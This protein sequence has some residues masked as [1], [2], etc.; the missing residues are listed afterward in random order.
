VSK[1]EVFTFKVDGELAELLRRIPNRS[2]FIRASLLAALGNLCPLCQGTG[3][4]SPAQMRHWE[5]FSSRHSITHC[6]SCGELCLSCSCDCGGH[7]AVE[8]VHTHEHDLDPRHSTEEGTHGK[9]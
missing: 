6:E 8:R 5:D 2:D 1:E 7:E 4:L 3:R 9:K